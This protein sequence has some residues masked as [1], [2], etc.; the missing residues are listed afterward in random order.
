MSL[1]ALRTIKGHICSSTSVVALLPKASVKVGWPKELDT[2]P[3]ILITQTGGADIGYLGYGTAAAGS[4]LRREE[5]TL[6]IDVFSRDSRRQT[7]QIADAVMKTLMVSSACRKVSD[8]D[9]YD[10]DL[11][12]YRKLQTFSFVEHYDD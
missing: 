6:Q 3:S 10:D 7:L 5:I 9:M 12:V 8:A 4:R 1:N 2:F 11:N